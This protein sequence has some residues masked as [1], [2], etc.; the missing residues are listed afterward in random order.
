MSLQNKIVLVTGA[1]RGIG[2]AIL[3]KLARAGAIALGVDYNDE[4][5]GVISAFLKELG[6]KGEGF[7]M[8]VTNQAS[9]EKCME[10]ISKKYGAPNVLVNNAGITRDNLILRMS[11]DDW[12]QVIATNLTSVFR[13]SRI[14]IRDM[15]K[16]RYGR[17]INIASVLAYMGN[18]GQANYTAAKAGIIALSKSMAAEVA[19]RNVTVNSVAPGFIESDMTKKLSTEQREKILSLVPMKRIGDPED[20]ANAVEFLASDN[21]AYITGS[22]VHVNGGMFM[23]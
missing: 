15:I 3:I 14:C 18:G 19:S 4:C 23:I 11:Q 10:E 16:A 20:V 22:T 21:A 9:I 2:K 5:A 12:D 8:D 1:S 7:V 6:L 13:L 17:I